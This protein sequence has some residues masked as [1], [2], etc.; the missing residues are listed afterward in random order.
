MRKDFITMSTK[1]LKR[2]HL[3]KKAEE[4]LI[5][6]TEAAKLLS[7]SSRQFRRII[8]TYRENG[9]HGLIHQSRG[10]P[11]PKKTAQ[12][13]VNRIVD[14]YKTEFLGYKPTFFCERIADEFNIHSNKE[15]IRQILITHN[16]WTPK[17]KKA[18]HRKKRE[19]KHHRGELVQF[20][21]SVHQW[22]EGPDGYCVLMLYIDD[23]TSRV[24]A[25]FYSYEGTFPALD[26]FRRYIQRYGIPLALYTDLHS[27]YRNNNK[28]LTIEEQIAGSKAHTQFS[29]AISE[30]AVSSIFAYSPQ[31]KG[32]VER[33]FGTFQD[34]LVK[35]LKRHKISSIPEANSFLP[36]FLAD[37]NK[38]FSFYPKDKLDL[39]RPAL[40][41][42]QLNKILC[43]KESRSIA[44]D[45]TIAYH[46]RIFQL[47]EATISKK[48]II[49]Q[50][51]NGRITIRI[52]QKS[53]PFKD[54]TH[55]FKHKKT[56]EKYVQTININPISLKEIAS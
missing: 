38:R 5:T 19:R 31:A 36:R 41:V 22:F 52:N 32:R 12:E 9:P 15:S 1:E 47:K 23:A 35:E 54:I 27:T 6:Q 3:A 37:F 33:S 13:K 28:V 49:E 26:S 56:K 50:L 55:K 25:R 30:L 39:H 8:K 17:M 7:L 40:P 53:I 18:N 45:F 16:L 34:R 10:K 4:D 2:L 42:F 43:R 48:A 20:D 11:S 14:L 24:F 51:P 21:G 29:R 44:K 46:N